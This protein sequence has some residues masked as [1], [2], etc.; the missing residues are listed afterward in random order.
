MSSLITDEASL[1]F[2]SGGQS[3]GAGSQQVR[4]VEPLLLDDDSKPLQKSR[5]A[6]LP[7][8]GGRH[9]A[10]QTQ[11]ESIVPGLD[12]ALIKCKDPVIASCT[13]RRLT[14]KILNDVKAKLDRAI[15]A[16]Q[17]AMDSFKDDFDDQDKVSKYFKLAAKST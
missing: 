11:Q 16:C 1:G 10:A 3:C 4:D 5:P 2:R 7:K 12:K 15:G 6:L 13:G 14:T 8:G 9:V 17:K